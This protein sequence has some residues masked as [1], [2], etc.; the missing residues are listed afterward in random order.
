VELTKLGVAFTIHE[1]EHDPRA[2]SFGIEAA[3]ALDLPAEQVFKTIIFMAES[4]SRMEP[5][6]AIS[7]VAWEID[8]K[9]V[10][11]ALNAKRISTCKPPDAERITGY[12]VG[13]ISPIAQKSRLRTV[14]DSGAR[15]YDRVYVSGGRRG[16]DISLSPTDLISV[17]QAEIAS[18]AARRA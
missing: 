9:A 15:D 16:M 3:A 13:G 10:A 8:T 14:L 11:R 18:I 5:V 4:G 12:V 7:P 17:T 1:Y 6:V 2:A